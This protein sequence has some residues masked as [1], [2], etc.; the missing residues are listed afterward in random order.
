MLAY[1]RN[2]TVKPFEEIYQAKRR[3]KKQQKMKSRHGG[4]DNL[5]TSNTD[6]ISSH[7][8]EELDNDFGDDDIQLGFL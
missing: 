2:S 4:G 6:P 1:H 7:L 5:S 8:D 3:L